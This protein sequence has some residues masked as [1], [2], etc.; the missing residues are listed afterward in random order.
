MIE[1]KRKKNKMKK[2]IILSLFLI[3][4]YPNVSFAAD[5]S[6]FQILSHKWNMC[7]FKGIKKPKFGGTKDEKKESSGLL[8]KLKSKSLW[9][10]IKSEENKNEEKLKQDEE[11]RLKQEAEQKLLAQKKAEEEI[12]TEEATESGN[13]KSLW[14]MLKVIVK[15]NKD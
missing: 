3:L 8:K 7:K 5:C 11:E 4:T 10:M 13:K 2:I 12:I 14:G 6:E 1:I 9:G 15:G